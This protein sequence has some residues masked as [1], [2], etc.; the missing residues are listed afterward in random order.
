MLYVSAPVKGYTDEKKYQLPNVACADRI[1]NSSQ[2]DSWHADRYNDNI[3]ANVLNPELQRVGQGRDDLQG[4][5]M[6]LQ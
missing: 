3:F 5:W 1:A 6:K 4:I 2:D